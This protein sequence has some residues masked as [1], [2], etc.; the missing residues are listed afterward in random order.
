MKNLFPL[1]LACCLCCP[2]PANLLAASPTRDRPAP[3][4]VS[5]EAAP[6]TEAAALPVQDEAP[7]SPEGEKAGTAPEKGNG[8][9]GTKAEKGDGKAGT[10]AEAA[11]DEAAPP[12]VSILAPELAEGGAAKTSEEK[13]AMLSDLVRQER[14]QARELAALNKAAKGKPT[15]TQKDQIAALNKQH[16]ETA[17]DFERIATGVELSMFAPESAKKPFDWKAEL[18]ALV[19]PLLKELRTLTAAARQ[20]AE[21]RE[22]LDVLGKQAQT[23]GQAAANLEA[24]SALAEDEGVKRQLAAL[25]DNWRDEE[26]RLTGK[27]ELARMDLHALTNPDESARDKSADKMRDFLRTRGLYLAMGLLAFAAA[28]LVLRLCFGLLAHRLPGAVGDRKGLYGRLA[29]VFAQFLSLFFATLAMLAVFFLVGDGFMISLA[30]L[31]VLG[32]LWGLRQTLPTQWRRSLFL[33]NMG[34][35]REGERLNIDGVPWRV[36]SLGMFCSLSNPALRQTLRLPLDRLLSQESR[37]YDMDEVW[38]PCQKGDCL[39]M[40]DGSVVQVTGLSSEQVSLVRVGTNMSSVWPAADF[41]KEKA[42]N[43]SRG[44]MVSAALG[45]SHGMAEEITDRAPEALREHLERRLADEGY[46]TKSRVATCEFGRMTPS[47]FEI[48]VTLEFPGD[49]APLYARL[50]RALERWCVDCCT[51]RGWELACPR[52]ELLRPAE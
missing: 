18:G 15:E 28:Y 43:L 45:L 33:L 2:L 14:D 36:D 50:R 38:F 47:G 46:E 22:T 7:A 41:I 37:P 12:L 34:S 31:L 48:A 24:L 40:G 5:R 19:D 32:G 6:A 11:L 10:K 8:K 25:L 20:K 13:L 1:L 52:L 51:E 26:K 3:V 21:L 27:L 23:A 9:A 39:L 17:R 44:F 30:V 49:M 29:G 42:L 4:P 16:A 35:V